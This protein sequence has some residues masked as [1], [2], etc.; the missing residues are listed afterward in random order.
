M[1]TEKSIEKVSPKP[2]NKVPVLAPGLA[3][4]LDEDGLWA[5]EKLPREVLKKAIFKDELTILGYKCAVFEMED[6]DLWA[7]KMNLV[8]EVASR[9]AGFNF[10]YKD[11]ETV[12]EEFDMTIDEVMEVISNNSEPGKLVKL[13]Q[14]Q[15]HDLIQ[16]YADGN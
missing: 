15:I 11:A 6:G 5:P 10:N 8:S 2:K 7:Q 9:I 1:P 12:A 3:F 13:N 14:E 16:I 4:H